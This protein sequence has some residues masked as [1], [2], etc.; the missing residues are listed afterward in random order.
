MKEFLVF[1]VQPNGDKVLVD[2]FESEEDARAK[3]EEVESPSLECVS[4]L[5]TTVLFSRERGEA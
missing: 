1:E 2:R 5:G 4:D 3:C